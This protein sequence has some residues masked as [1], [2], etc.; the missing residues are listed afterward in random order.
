M[1]RRMGH[2]GRAPKG[3]AETSKGGKRW[4]DGNSERKSEIRREGRGEKVKTAQGGRDDGVRAERDHSPGDGG[5]GVGAEPRPRP[6]LTSRP[7]AP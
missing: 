2:G 7:P 3:E 6:P 5:A 4:R 1:G